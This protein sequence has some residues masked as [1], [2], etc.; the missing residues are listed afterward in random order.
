MDVEIDGRVVADLSLVLVRHAKQAVLHVYSG[1]KMSRLLFQVDLLNPDYRARSS[2]AQGKG[3]STV[4][5]PMPGKVT[6]ILVK[7]G[8]QV[9]AN[10]TLLVL[11]AMKMEHSVRAPRA[12]VVQSISVNV[13]ALVGD[14]AEMCSLE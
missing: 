8:D 3:V 2:A 11:E 12:G 6:R 7:P 4:A 5:S 14:G 10:Q 1:G 13:G 9:E